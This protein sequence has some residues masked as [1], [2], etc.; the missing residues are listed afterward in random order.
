LR[1]SKAIDEVARVK[2]AAKSDGTPDSKDA[3]QGSRN[4]ERL[5]RAVEPRDVAQESEGPHESL[6]EMRAARMPSKPE[7]S[8][9]ESIRTTARGE[10][11]TATPDISTERNE[12]GDAASAMDA[13][14][15]TEIHITIGSVELRAPRVVPVPPKAP[16]FRPRVTLDEF[17]KRGSGSGGWGAKS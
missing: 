1:R 2:E 16:A 6:I 17:L 15:H 11:G 3:D 14:E 13:A 5:E 8:E 12:A 4:R 7:V 9:S 10:Q